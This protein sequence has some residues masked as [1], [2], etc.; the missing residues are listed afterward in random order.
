MCDKTYTLLFQLL[1]EFCREATSADRSGSVANRVG[2]RVGPPLRGRSRPRPPQ[3]KSQ[4]QTSCQVRKRQGW[5]KG[6][7]IGAKNPPRVGSKDLSKNASSNTRCVGLR[8]IEVESGTRTEPPRPN[9]RAFSPALSVLHSGLVPEPCSGTGCRARW[10]ERQVEPG[11]PCARVL[12]GLVVFPAHGAA[13]WNS[14]VPG[15]G[16]ACVWRDLWNLPP[17]PGAPVVAGMC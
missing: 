5:G 16:S 14:R 7:R 2:V 11:D 9:Q 1:S 3:K 15:A 17:G 8:T 6:T 13:L 4:A 12:S 10:G